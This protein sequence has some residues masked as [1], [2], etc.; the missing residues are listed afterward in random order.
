MNIRKLSIWL[1]ALYLLFNL[2]TVLADEGMWL[3]LFISR[4]NQEDMQKKGLHLTADEIYS[5][6]HS[7]LKD[8]II[9]LNHGSCTAEVISD[10]GLILTN[11]HCGFEAIQQLSSMENNFLDDGFFAKSIDEEK[12]VR[13]MTASFLVRIEDVT[14]IVLKDINDDTEQA[15]R[16]KL[17][18]TRSDSLEKAAV[19]KNDYEARVKSFFSGNE[20][21]LFVYETFSDLR[22]VGAPPA[23]IGKFG[24][25]TD[26]WMWPRHTGDFS[27]FRIYSDP[28]GKPADYSK[29][30][31]PLK[32][33]KSLAVSLDGVKKDDF[34]MIL[35]YPGSTDRYM[36][37]YGL[38]LAVESTEP[39][40]VKIREKRLE[41]MEADMA[42]DSEIRL[43]YASKHARVS[44][45]YK[46]FKGQI[47]GLKRLKVYDKKK[48]E[49]DA[50]TAWVKQDDGRKEK[51]GKILS[52]Y[53][54]VY[55]QINPYEIASTYINE[56]FFGIEINLLCMRAFNLYSKLKGETQE[57]ITKAA[58]GFKEYAERYY[59]NYNVA[60]DK[61]VFSALMTL[62]NSDVPPK[63]Q[64]PYMAEILKKNHGSF[65]T[66]ANKVFSKSIFADKEKLFAFIDN[67][68]LKVL[69]KD[70]A[71]Q[72]VLNIMRHY[73]SNVRPQLIALQSSLDNS[74]RLRMEGLMAMNPKKQWYSNANSSMRFTYGQ[75]EDYYP[76]D[77][78]YYNYFTTLKGVIEKED[79]SNFEF[80]VPKKLKELYK[81]KDYGQYGE[82]GVMKVNFLSTNDITGGNSGSPVINGSGELV[83]CAF[84]GNW[85]AMSGD[86]AFENEIQRTISVDIRYVLFIIDKFAGA[87]YL[88]NEMNLVSHKND[89]AQ[90]GK[91]KVGNGG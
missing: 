13:G 30:N 59:K 9:M 1:T 49:E 67:P 75:V 63:L 50:F 4:L 6:N 47:R 29:D 69:D 16:N 18:E 44:N 60:T 61:K 82:N 83:G 88:V 10:K 54:N 2:G 62:Y 74:D 70:P 5:V 41:I 87:K 79:S 76:Q 8:A 27:L 65:E 20:Y 33:K 31:I 15:E 90:T 3:P 7:S 37:S 39:A 11:H 34:T 36:T 72:L 46:Y 14:A 86:I 51:Y 42:R 85:E 12:I 64:P 53:E 56:C 19:E 40:I 28:D 80:V 66:F 89:K 25:D 35:G 48:A 78:V 91:E 68:S 21:Y 24:G 22:F 26:N 71:F 52:D 32:P 43:K 77:A 57:D 73:M 55:K 23:S 81:S 84:D 45:Y 58:D 38:K 17:I